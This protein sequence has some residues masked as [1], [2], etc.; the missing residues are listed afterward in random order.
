MLPFHT[1]RCDTRA[2]LMIDVDPLFH[3]L[4]LQAH[5]LFLIVLSGWMSYNASVQ[6][7]KLK[8]KFWGQR[9][10]VKVHSDPH[11]AVHM[12]PLSPA[13]AAAAANC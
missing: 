9:Y 3:A 7:Y 4:P 11:F 12:I 8:Y 10:N 6:A 1:L 2:F 5:N 13:A